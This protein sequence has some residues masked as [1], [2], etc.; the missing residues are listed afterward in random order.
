MRAFVATAT[1]LALCGCA[2]P[3]F[4]A[5]HPGAQQGS[6]R[7]REA[8]GSCLQQMLASP[9]IQALKSKFPP[10]EPGS[11]PSQAQLA[12][13]TLATPQEAK[14]VL[15]FHQKYIVPC[16]QEGLVRTSTIGPQPVAIVVEGFAT[17]DALI[18]KLVE[19][20]MTWGEY[21]RTIQVLRTDARAYLAAVAARQHSNPGLEDLAEDA[22]QH[23]AAMVAL[24][25]WKRQQQALVQK[26][27]Q[28]NPGD[29][30][31]LN[32]CTYFS[33][34]VTCPML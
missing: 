2:T 13:P 20:K 14:L 26:Q 23:Q 11:L 24:E 16:R 28:L 4:E 15:S 25:N 5:R 8:T 29:P 18:L 33:A 9:E 22:R 32:D 30:A 1:L 21:N 10:L 17:A 7:A 12:D 31:R 27:R 34:T 19:G 3:D 6:P